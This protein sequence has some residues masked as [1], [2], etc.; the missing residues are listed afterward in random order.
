MLKVDADDAETTVT[1]TAGSRDDLNTVSSGGIETKWKRK[2]YFFSINAILFVEFFAITCIIVLCLFQEN[3]CTILNSHSWIPYLTLTCYLCLIT[4]LT[5]FNKLIA[6]Y[7][8][9]LF[10]LILMTF[11]YGSFLGSIA[12]QFNTL[13]VAVITS[14]TSLV[15]GL[16][17]LL[18]LVI[19]CDVTHWIFLVVVPIL[20]LVVVPSMAYIAHGFRVFEPFQLVV[21]GLLTMVLL[22]LLVFSMQSLIKG[23]M[24]QVHSNE[25]IR[26]VLQLYTHR[27]G[28]LVQTLI[29]VTQMFICWGDPRDI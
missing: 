7:P 8:L 12:V 3:L 6:L 5:F 18:A 10:A 17:S 2:K 1:S 22:T 20:T 9:N 26:G 15:L 21:S 16:L 13:S 4:I 28:I 23:E 25:R 19:P 11:L 29:T 27:L 14:S 24:G